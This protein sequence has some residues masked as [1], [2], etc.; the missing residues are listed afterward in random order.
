MQ[1]QARNF[2]SKGKGNNQLVV[3]GESDE[4]V[5]HI[6]NSQLGEVFTNFADEYLIDLHITDQKGYNNYPLWLKATFYIPD[7]TNQEKVKDCAKL[8]KAL[9]S[10]VDRVVTLRLSPQNRQK[11]D[12][13][14]RA[15]ERVKAQE[16]AVE[17][18]DAVL[19]KKREEKLKFQEKLKSLPP[20]QQRKLEEKKRE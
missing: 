14:R 3:L 18:E 19:Q 2:T 1:I 8:L 5:N 9:F 15:A 10:V 6:L 4:T 17:N 11:A 16:K 13:P 20:D 7:P 12:K